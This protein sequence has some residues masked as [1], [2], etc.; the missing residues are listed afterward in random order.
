MTTTIELAREAGLNDFGVGWQMDKMEAFRAL[1]VAERDRELLAT[2]MGPVGAV[3]TLRGVTHCTLTQELGDTDLHTAAQLAA[4]AAVAAAKIRP[5][6]CHHA[7]EAQAFKIEIR[8]LNRHLAEAQAKA[9]NS[10]SQLKALAEAHSSVLRERDALQSQLAEM[11]AE[12]DAL[13][14]ANKDLQ[15]WFDGHDGA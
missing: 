13:Q 5:A 7:C 6:P 14:A 3:Y 12:R 15:Q 9:D 8:Q 2:G 1:I 11:K 4:Q 10:Y